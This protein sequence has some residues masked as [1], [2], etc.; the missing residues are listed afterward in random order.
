M[1]KFLLLLVLMALPVM[2]VAQDKVLKMST[3]TSTEPSACLRFCWFGSSKDTA[4]M[5]GVSAGTGA[6]IRDGGTATT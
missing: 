5:L 2:S 6:A 4:L 3:T 1:K